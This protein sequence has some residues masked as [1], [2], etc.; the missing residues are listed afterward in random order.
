[1]SL[2]LFR[3]V[4]HR[5]LLV[6]TRLAAVHRFPGSHLQLRQRRILPRIRSQERQRLWPERQADRVLV[7]ERRRPFES[8]LGLYLLRVVI[9][10]VSNVTPKQLG[11]MPMQRIDK[12]KDRLV[13]THTTCS[14]MR[15]NLEVMPQLES[16]GTPR[17][18]RY[19]LLP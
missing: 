16:L 6:R 19:P 8:E 11:I 15:S 4:Y 1:M 5:P 2:K 17:A 3:D 7:Q 10:V 12:G 9:S 18:T 13:T 14:I